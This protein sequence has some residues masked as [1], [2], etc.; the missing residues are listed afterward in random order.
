MM[1]IAGCCAV[2]NEI[3]PPVRQIRKAEPAAPSSL[4]SHTTVGRSELDDAHEVHD[5]C[6]V[7][8][9]KAAV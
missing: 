5:V 1:P 7:H 2:F 9:G 3:G 6:P 8:E 4:N